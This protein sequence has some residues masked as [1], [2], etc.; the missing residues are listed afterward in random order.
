[1]GLSP[2]RKIDQITGLWDR[3]IIT[4]PQQ[5]IS[6]LEFGN[7]ETMFYENTLF[8]NKA[9]RILKAIAEGKMKKD[10]TPDIPKFNS[11]DKHD[12]FM[13]TFT[14]FIATIGYD[15]MSPS[16]QAILDGLMEQHSQALQ[17]AAMAAQGAPPGPNGGSGGALPTQSGMDASMTN[18][19]RAP[20][21]AA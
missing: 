1:M 18:G 13:K 11:F 19:G 10:G 21:T 16:Q 2:S 14:N 17:Q 20:G 3:Q 8:E 6:M 5:I 7:T 4:D 12:I 9:R 15:K